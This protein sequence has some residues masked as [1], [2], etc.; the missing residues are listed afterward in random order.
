[1][2]VDESWVDTENYKQMR[3]RLRG[4]TNTIN[5]KQII[6]RISV[7]AAL[8][9]EGEVFLSMSIVTTDKDTFRVFISKLV[10]KLDL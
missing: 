6:P 2:N 4:Q 8:D 10:E 1:M 5:F 9:T 7:I 3:W